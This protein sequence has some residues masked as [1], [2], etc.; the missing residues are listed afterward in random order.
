MRYLVTGGAGFVGSH[1]V[2]ALHDRGHEVVVLDNL[3]TGHHQ[4]IPGGVTLRQVDLMDLSATQECVA[5]GPWDGV[6]HFAALSLVG[7]SMRNP[8]HYIRY[9]TQ[10]ALNLI[11]ACIEHNVRKIVFSS[12]AALF[13]GPER[14]TPIPDDALIQPGSPYGESKLMIERTLYWADQIHQ[15]RSG[16]LRYFNA[17]G[18]DPQG[19]AGEDHRPETHLI[20]LTI[21]AAL[22]RRPALQLFGTDYPTAD[23]SCIRD[24]IHVT[25]LADAHI[26]LL[27][28]IDDRSVRYNVGTGHGYS[29]LDVI[30]SVE[31]VTGHTVPWEAAPRR[32]GDPAMLVADASILRRDTGWTPQF[33]DLDA[34]IE[35]V[36][37]W[38]SAHP[39]GYS[40]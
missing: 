26:R 13:G 5:D 30:R 39:H 31:R 22:G 4:A 8:L 24:Y 28:Q 9:N 21:D 27:D 37:K 12:T 6:F 20:P 23:G 2:L 40:D 10:T 29:N 17:A 25:D 15:L 1:L 34:I 33:T 32:A 3:S 36:F 14:T 11:Q 18:S 38:R 7:D 16:C 35:T 19:R